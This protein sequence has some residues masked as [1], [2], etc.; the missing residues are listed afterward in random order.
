MTLFLVL[1]SVAVFV[2]VWICVARDSNTLALPLFVAAFFMALGLVAKNPYAWVLV[3]QF[4]TVAGGQMF[5]WYDEHQF[6]NKK[7]RWR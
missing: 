5:D 7:G 3:T 6:R 1:G 4:L 2:C